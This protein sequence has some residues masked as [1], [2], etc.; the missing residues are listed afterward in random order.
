MPQT[1][2]Q[3]TCLTIKS[4]ISMAIIYAYAVHIVLITI[5][6][7]I[8]LWGGGF[9]MKKYYSLSFILPKDSSV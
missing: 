5:V 7:L 6:R 8:I 9:N 2:T 3:L 4:L 1:P